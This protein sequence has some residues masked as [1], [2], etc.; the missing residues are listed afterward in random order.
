MTGLCDVTGRVD[1]CDTRAG[2][3]EDEGDG[4]EQAS[5]TNN[6]GCKNPG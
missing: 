4:G 1:D 6:G 5:K 2:E 3:E